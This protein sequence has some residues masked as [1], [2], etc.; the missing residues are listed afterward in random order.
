[1][2]KMSSLLRG[3]FAVAPS[4]T[5]DGCATPMSPQSPGALAA[6][7]PCHPA[8]GFGTAPAS[9]RAALA[10]GSGRHETR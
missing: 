2:H 6:G 9:A 8:E 5:T 1:M 10:A 4:P 3:L 7:A